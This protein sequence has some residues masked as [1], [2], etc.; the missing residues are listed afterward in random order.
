MYNLSP[1]L[2]RPGVSLRDLI[3]HRIKVGSFSGNRDQ[4]IAD[5]LTSISKGKTV[6]QRPRARRPLHLD[7]QP[8]DG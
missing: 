6:S 1:E 7:L 2:T 5:L 8:A 3:D 4:Y